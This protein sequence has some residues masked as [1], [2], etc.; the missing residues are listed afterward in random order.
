MSNPHSRT[1]IIRSETTPIYPSSVYTFPSLDDVADF[2]AG[3][4]HPTYLYRRNGHP[5]ENPVEQL[6]AAWEHTE[7]AT[8]FSSGMAAISQACMAVLRPGDHI[9]TTQF[10]YGGTYA[11]FEQILRPWGIDITYLNVDSLAELEAAVKPNTR[12]LFAETIANPLLQVLDLAVL[13]QF[14]KLHK[15]YFFVDNTFATPLLTRPVEL[16]ADL[17]IHSL[18]KF[19]NGHSDVIGG[20]VAGSKELVAKVRAFSVTFGGTFAPFDAWLTER[21]MKTFPLRYP[22]ACENALRVAQFLDS[23]PHVAKV[24]YPGLPSH[25]SHEVALCMLS[26]HFGAMLSFE[27]EGGRDAA[28]QVISAFSHIRFAPS[29]GGTETTC[30]H[31]ALTSHR[32]YSEKEREALGIHWGLIRMSIGIEPIDVILTDLSQALSF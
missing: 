10:L 1:P 22:A 21:G 2:Y 17:S 9:L 18:T 32:A 7:S 26:T 20:A 16:G 23:H 12:L 19:L 30:S 8:L 13:S 27:L 14:S 28:N 11:L 24:Y 5:N 4:E 6:L 3:P 25:P 31:P 15:L 29:L